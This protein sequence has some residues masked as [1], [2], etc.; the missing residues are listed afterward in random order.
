A[1]VAQHRGRRGPA[2]HEPAK[3]QRGAKAAQYVGHGATGVQLTRLRVAA[4]LEP[5]RDEGPAVPRRL[6][7]AAGVARFERGGVRAPVAGELRFE[8][9]EIGEL[10]RFRTYQPGCERPPS[11]PSSV[12]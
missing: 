1:G 11:K 6:G 3:H 8:I 12:A 10:H 9:D 4:T 7:K 2:D 5:A